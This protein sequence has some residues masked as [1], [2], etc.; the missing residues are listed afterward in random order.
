[1]EDVLDTVLGQPAGAGGV[2][3]AD[4]E[5]GKRPQLAL[6]LLTGGAPER[7]G[8]AGREHGPLVAGRDDRLHGLVDQFPDRGREL[9]SPEPDPAILASL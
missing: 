9:R 8:C 3:G 5:W 1:V 7:S 6:D 4:L 2:G